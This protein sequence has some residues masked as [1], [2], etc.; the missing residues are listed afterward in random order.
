VK[1]KSDDTALLKELKEQERQA[2]IEVR[3]WLERK[4]ITDPTNPLPSRSSS[5]SGRRC[6]RMCRDRWIR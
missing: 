2:A 1:V 6:R 5:S 3:Q 4:E